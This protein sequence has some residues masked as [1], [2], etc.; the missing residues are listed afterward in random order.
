MKSFKGK[1]RS[2]KFL[3]EHQISKHDPSFFIADPLLG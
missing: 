1:M 3:I 2:F